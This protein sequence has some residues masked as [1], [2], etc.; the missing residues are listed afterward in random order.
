MYCVH[1]AAV[2]LTEAWRR[3]R[4]DRR[5]VHDDDEKDG[6]RQQHSDS[7]RYFLARTR[8]QPKD[9]Q[10]NNCHQR[11]GQDDIVDVVKNLRVEHSQQ[12]I[13]YLL[14]RLNVFAP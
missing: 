12:Y 8:R 11:N 6:E 10:S 3:F 14:V 1:K 9:A 13:I 5:V 4:V 2:S 7:Q